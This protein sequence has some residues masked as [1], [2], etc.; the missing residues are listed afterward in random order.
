MMGQERKSDHG[1]R[2][3]KE[4]YLALGL[5]IHVTPKIG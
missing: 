4:R 2:D 3:R 5:L 1:G